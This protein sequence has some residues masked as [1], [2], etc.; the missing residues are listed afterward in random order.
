ML[1]SVKFGIT[2]FTA[3]HAEKRIYIKPSTVYVNYLVFQARLDD[4]A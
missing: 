3:E 4:L 1:D 2:F